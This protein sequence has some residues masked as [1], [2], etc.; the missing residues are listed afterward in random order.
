MGLKA[1]TALFIIFVLFLENLTRT[2][3]SPT[4]KM[5]DSNSVETD[6]KKLSKKL[7][8]SFQNLYN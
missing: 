8:L 7:F 6:E 5:L 3:S 4:P 2:I 1:N